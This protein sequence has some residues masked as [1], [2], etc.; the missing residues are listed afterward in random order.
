MYTRRLGDLVSDFNPPAVTLQPDGTDVTAAVNKFK[1]LGGSIK[2]LIAQIRPNVPDTNLNQ[3]GTDIG[4]VVNAFKKFKYTY[5]GPCVC[6]SPISC[7][8]ACAGPFGSACG[9]GGTCLSVCVS[10]PRTG[11]LCNF[12]QDCGTCVGGANDGAQCKAGVAPN[13]C[14]GGACTVGVCGANQGAY[15][16]RWTSRL[17]YR[18]L[19]LSSRV[20]A[21]HLHESHGPAKDRAAHDEEQEGGDC[22]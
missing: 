12:N 1:N 3:D 9:G 19:R 18:V 14:P 16:V 8:L 22:Q 20:G 10:G 2:K 13:Y 5:S 21:K 11:E 15:G 6:P 17:P 4:E 7:T